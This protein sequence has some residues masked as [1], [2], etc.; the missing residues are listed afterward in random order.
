MRACEVEPRTEVG[1]PRPPRAPLRPASPGTRGGL[2]TAQPPPKP[3]LLLH[4]SPRASGGSE[5]YKQTR[6]SSQTRL[7]AL[8]SAISPRGTGS[9]RRRDP[10]LRGEAEQGGAAL[11]LTGVPGWAHPTLCKS[12]LAFRQHVP[13]QCH[14]PVV[15]DNALP[16]FPV[17]YPFSEG[18]NGQSPISRSNS[19]TI[20]L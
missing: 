5:T 2:A 18:P 20:V 10:N 7:S 16:Q 12:R 9:P 6:P 19:T 8:P 11:L 15:G 3:L 13:C 1:A 4:P 17:L 14:L